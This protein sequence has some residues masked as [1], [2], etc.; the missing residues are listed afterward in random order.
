MII[1]KRKLFTGISVNNKFYL[2][3]YGAKA[4]GNVQ[5]SDDRN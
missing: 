4:S 2:S 3:L 1:N 5:T